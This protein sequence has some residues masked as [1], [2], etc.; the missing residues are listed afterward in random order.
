MVKKE[1]L[2]QTDREI[3][4]KVSVRRRWK[5]GGRRSR[6]PI[7]ECARLPSDRTPNAPP[8]AYKRRKGR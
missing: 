2:E 8:K 4:T 7:P 3:P 6:N 5:R 1:Q